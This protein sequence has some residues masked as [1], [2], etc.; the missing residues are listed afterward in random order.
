LP[1]VSASSVAA[2]DSL[3]DSADLLVDFTTGKDTID[4]SEMSAKEGVTLN[5]VSQYSG[6]A[7][8]TILVRNPATNRYFLGID[9]TGDRKTD[10][11]IK[12]TRPIS[13]ED[14]IG[15]NLPVGTYL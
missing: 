15:L 9:L 7:G 4:L 5:Y 11:L 13:S 8:D 10:F 14:V 6:R 1:S 3:R 12:S 2:A